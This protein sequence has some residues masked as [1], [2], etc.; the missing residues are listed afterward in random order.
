M[1]DDNHIAYWDF[2]LARDPLR[3]TPS[4]VVAPPLRSRARND[5]PEPKFGLAC[6]PVGV[7][8]LLILMC[9]DVR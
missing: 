6:G 5:G 9:G 7:L 2:L 1:H 4:P 8:V 3:Q